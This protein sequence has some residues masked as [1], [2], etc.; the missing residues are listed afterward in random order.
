MK[1]GKKIATWIND[2]TRHGKFV[3][4]PGRESRESFGWPGWVI[5]ILS[6]LGWLLLVLLYHP[7]S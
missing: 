3:W 5:V 6:A 4:E 2:G 7:K 1:P